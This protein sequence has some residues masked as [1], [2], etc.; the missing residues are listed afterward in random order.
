MID[1]VSDASGD[2]QPSAA[3]S[4]VQL[5]QQRGSLRRPVHRHRRSRVRLHHHV[6]SHPLVLTSP[7]SRFTFCA[8]NVINQ[9]STLPVRDPCAARLWFVAATEMNDVPEGDGGCGRSFTRLD[10]NTRL[11]LHVNNSIITRLKQK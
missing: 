6:V 5:Q 11:Y 3:G 4:R 1:I 7:S 2:S 9:S 10:I 8:L